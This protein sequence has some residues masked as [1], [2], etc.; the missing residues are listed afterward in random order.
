VLIHSSRLELGYLGRERKKETAEL[1]SGTGTA[2]G[3]DCRGGMVTC[4]VSFLNFVM[5]K[6]GQFFINSKISR[7]YTTTRGVSPCG[8]AIYI[9]RYLK[10]T[11]ELQKFK[12]FTMQKYSLQKIL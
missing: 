1:A 6:I 9:K 8:L 7:T 5:S 2:P 12:Y 4:Q 3:I 10:E 11:E